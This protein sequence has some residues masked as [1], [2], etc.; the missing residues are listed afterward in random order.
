[1]ERESLADRIEDK[2]AEAG[3]YVHV[4]LTEE[5]VL[6]DGTV[7]DLSERSL[8]E[9]IA[10]HVAEN[11]RIENNLDVVELEPAEPQAGEYEYL[12]EPFG[13]EPAVVLGAPED[14]GASTY[15]PPTDPVLENGEVVGGFDA[16]SMD[17]LE[18]EPSVSGVG[19]GDDALAEAVRRELRE[20]AATTDLPIRVCVEEGI[21]HLRGRVLSIEDVENAEEVAGRLPGVREVVEEL[22]IAG[23]E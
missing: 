22:D 14:N 1:M 7:N 16:T 3:I 2:L 13:Q 9:E 19:P 4:G 8:A 6:L 20:D 5:G 18:V 17:S 23:V 12:E 21:V 11:R 15:F 10:G